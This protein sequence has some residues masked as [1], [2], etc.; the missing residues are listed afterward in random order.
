MLHCPNCG[1]NMEIE[2]DYIY[3]P[4]CGSKVREAFDNEGAEASLSRIGQS[5]EMKVAKLREKIAEARH[6][7]QIGWMS[8]GIAI[9]IVIALAIIHTQIA[10]GNTLFVSF[11]SSP[12]DYTLANLSAGLIIL[13]TILVILGVA[14]SIYARRLRTRLLKEFENIDT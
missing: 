9:I 13:A 7:E 12:T 5:L 10:A 6:N 2:Q 14:L 4:T 3:C 8:V 1:N 11:D